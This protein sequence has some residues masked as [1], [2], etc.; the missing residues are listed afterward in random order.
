M[1]LHMSIS[2]PPISRD[3]WIGVRSPANN[4]SQNN[5]DDAKLKRFTHYN[6]ADAGDHGKVMK[7]YWDTAVEVQDPGSKRLEHDGDNT[8]IVKQVDAAF[9]R[10]TVLELSEQ[11][12]NE[13]YAMRTNN[14]EKNLETVTATIKK[15]KTFFIPIL[16]RCL[17][18]GIMLAHMV[19]FRFGVRVQDVEWTVDMTEW[20]ES[21]VKK[22]GCSVVT[23]L[24]YVQTGEAAIE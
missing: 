17:L 15:Y 13:M 24:R 7:F 20:E 10:K 19:V 12:G 21:D 9:K 11:I 16:E 1:I 22:V 8:K 5:T 18:V 4:D 23:L 2:P 14:V 3:K 6:N